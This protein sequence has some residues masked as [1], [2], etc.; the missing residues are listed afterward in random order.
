MT[1]ENDV[2]AL[3]ATLAD[4]LRPEARTRTNGTAGP[5]QDAADY[6][7][8]LPLDNGLLVDLTASE[9]RP[10][11]GVDTFDLGPGWLLIGRYDPRTV[12]VEEP[13]VGIIETN[14][15]DELAEHA[16]DGNQ[17]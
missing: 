16:D 17:P 8:C 14:L 7:S 13:I 3:R 2:A 4:H 6:V 9:T 5:L 1:D 15:E 12:S 11:A 10:G